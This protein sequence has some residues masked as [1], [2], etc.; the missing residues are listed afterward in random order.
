MVP[1]LTLN[2]ASDQVLVV[3]LSEPHHL[4]LLT[5]VA[6]EKALNKQEADR[7]ERTYHMGAKP[8]PDLDYDDRLTVRLKKSENTVYAYLGLPEKD[9]GL[10]HKRIGKSYLVTERAILEFLGDIKPVA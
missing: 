8:T 2:L 5:A 3:T 4:R 10:R 1:A 6:V 7:L 9:G